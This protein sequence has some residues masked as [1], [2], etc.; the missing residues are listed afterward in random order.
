MRA[1]LRRLHRWCGLSVA[2]F[3]LA[4]SLTGSLI[5]FEHELDAWLNPELFY[6]GTTGKALPLDALIARIEG[7][8]SRLR[9]TQMPLD[10][11]PGQ[12]REVQVET[13]AITGSAR[14]PIGF[15]RLFVDPTTGRVLGARQWGVWQWD[16]AHLMP[17]MNRFHRSLTLPGRI[18]NQLLGSVAVVWLSISFAGLYLTLPAKL[19]TSKTSDPGTH[20][21][22]G[23]TY[24]S[25]WK[26]AWQIKRGAKGFRRI[27]DLHRAA[28]LWVLLLTLS[29]AFT[30]IYL[31]LGNELF[32]PAVSLFGPITPHPFTTIP[33]ARVP[34]AT[35][36]TLSPEQGLKLAR[37]LLPD[38]ARHYENWYLG[39]DASR[40]LYR[41]A[42]KERG[43]REHILRVRYEQIFVDAESGNLL[44]R[45]GYISG[46][47]SDR[48]LVWLYPVHS[49]K[50][51]GVPGRLAISL[52]GL[53]VALICVTGVLRW[54]KRKNAKV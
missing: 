48:F 52:G 13:K 15:D 34:L 38:E 26:P 6:T 54:I 23:A 30:G 27:N 1:L 45:F 18:G 4:S 24:W 33:K 53:F 39:Y 32:K 7:Q 16:R 35:S 43:L 36:P 10:T 25:R 51:L 49:G 17:W 3:L 46:T 31:N 2:V 28:G 47:A 8:D 40:G 44:S 41:A 37:E 5:A 50:L 19:K 29:T 12:A 14:A 20:R 21:Q 42:F 11:E 9:V 22:A